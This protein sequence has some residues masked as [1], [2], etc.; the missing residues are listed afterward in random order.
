VLPFEKAGRLFAK[1]CFV[2]E[3]MDV[4]GSK[5]EIIFDPP[6]TFGDKQSRGTINVDFQ[7]KFNSLEHEDNNVKNEI[8]REWGKRKVTNPNLF[9]GSKFRYYGLSKSGNVTT[10]NLG[11]TSYGS[12]LGT[13]HNQKLAKKLKVDGIE[14]HNNSQVYMADPLGVGAIVTTS[15]NYIIAFKRSKLVGEFPEHIDVPGGH[16]EPKDVGID[17]KYLE[18]GENVKFTIVQ[19][20][21]IEENYITREEVTSTTAHGDI[22][23]ADSVK[24]TRDTQP[25]SLNTMKEQ[26]ISMKAIL[27]ELFNSILMEVHLE[28]NIP[29]VNLTPPQLSGIFRQIGKPNG[30]ASLCFAT[31]C[32]LSSNEVKDFF[33]L[34][35]KEAD[36]STGPLIFIPKHEVLLGSILNNGKEEKYKFTPATAACLNIHRQ[37]HSSNN[38]RS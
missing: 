23:S 27:A 5:I 37:V 10:I 8:Q 12:F 32:S 15:D 14:K 3:T 34:G 21:G 30:R 4:V 18:N 24:N 25:K 13:N 9:D 26:T 35:P 20:K 7:A 38:N 19:N 17:I 29:L 2:N 6:I 22:V 1:H 28:T 33:A 31:N 11:L 36:E 16:P